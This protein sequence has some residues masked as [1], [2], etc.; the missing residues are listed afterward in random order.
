MALHTRN[1]PEEDPEGIHLHVCHVPAFV[2]IY[3]EYG[4][5]PLCHGGGV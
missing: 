1:Y 2:S 4:L 5:L 3:T